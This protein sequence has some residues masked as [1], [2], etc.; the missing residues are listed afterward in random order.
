MERPKG[1]PEGLLCNCSELRRKLVDKNQV[2]I[3]EFYYSLGI[4]R[5]VAKAQFLIP[6]YVLSPPLVFS[7]FPG[8]DVAFLLQFAKHIRNCGGEQDMHACEINKSISW[9]QKVEY[10]QIH[11]TLTED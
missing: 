4:E 1:G 5:E 11:T 9:T 2:S 3:P 7:V 10:A 6:V 8:V